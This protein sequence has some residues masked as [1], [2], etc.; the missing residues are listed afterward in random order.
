MNGAPF[1]STIRSPATR[2]LALASLP[3]RMNPHGVGLA[4]RYADAR[5]ASVGAAAR[6]ATITAVTASANFMLTW[7]IV[8]GVAEARDCAGSARPHSRPHRH[9]RID[10]RQGHVR[11][12]AAPRAGARRR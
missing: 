7:R 11:G 2:S 6:H 12:D 1:E 8:A 4:P 3:T 5:S 10:R 9:R